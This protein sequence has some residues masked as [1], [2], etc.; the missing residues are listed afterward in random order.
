MKTIALIALINTDAKIRN[1]MLA[2]RIQQYVK[3]I[4]PCPSGFIP[5]VQGLFNV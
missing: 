3:R 1:K 4:T 5:G 2:N